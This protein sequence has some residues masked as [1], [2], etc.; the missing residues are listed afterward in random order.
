[1]D[2]ASVYEIEDRSSTL[3]K[4]NNKNQGGTKMSTEK[5]KPV[6]G[7]SG[8]FSIPHERDNGY[9]YNAVTRKWVKV[10]KE[11]EEKEEPE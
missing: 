7:V 3:L 11:K 9:I 10:E 1:M 6:K 4:G 8:T 2:K 5:D